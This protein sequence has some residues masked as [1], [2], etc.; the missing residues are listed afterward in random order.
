MA[1]TCNNLAVFCEDHGKPEEGETLYREALEIYRRLAE[2]VSRGAYEP[3]LARTLFNMSLFYE[4]RDPDRAEEYRREA[5]RIAERRK[6]A[7]PLCRQIW[8]ALSE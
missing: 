2:S 7:D 8:E 6:D 1:T 5:K 3:D 4:N